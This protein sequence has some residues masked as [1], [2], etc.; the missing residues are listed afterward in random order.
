[1]VVV[2]P[3]MTLRGQ[4]FSALRWTVGAKFIS[5]LA[6]WAMTLIVIR[7]LTPS[8]YGLLAM[9]S[10]LIGF[11]AMLSDIGIGPALVQR[12]QID[13]DQFRKGF[14]IVL[15]IHFGAALTIFIVAPLMAAFF[16]VP[17]LTAVMR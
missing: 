2:P 15:L 6:T 3:Y 12:E 9:A 4:V 5:Q 11:L 10:V 14:G 8:D 1:M 17:R 16:E 7:L 13:E